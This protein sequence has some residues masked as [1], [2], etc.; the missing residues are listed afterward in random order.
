M[1][2]RRLNLLMTFSPECVPIGRVLDRSFLDGLRSRYDA[3]M[4]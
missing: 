1:N 2:W 3:P 4:M